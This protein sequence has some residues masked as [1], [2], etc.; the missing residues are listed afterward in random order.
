M[1]HPGL[2]EVLTAVAKVKPLKELPEPDVRYQLRLNSGVR[3]SVAAAVVG[4]GQSSIIRWERGE[5]TPKG[6]SLARYLRLLAAFRAFA[7]AP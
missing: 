1:L 3:I 2:P 4:L 6:A 7:E 5:V